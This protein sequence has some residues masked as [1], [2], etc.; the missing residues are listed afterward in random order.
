MTNPRKA[1]K[2]CLRWIVRISVPILVFTVVSG[3]G[4][5]VDCNSLEREINRRY[6][7]PPAGDEMSDEEFVE[8]VEKTMEMGDRYAEDCAPYYRGDGDYGGR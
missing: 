3:C 5:T 7:N 4:D 8:F 1:R 2:A 6:A